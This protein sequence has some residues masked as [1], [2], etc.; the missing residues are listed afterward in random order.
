MRLRTILTS[1]YPLREII[2]RLGELFWF[3][4]APRFLPQ[5]LRY[6]VVLH[7]GVRHIQSG[8]IV[9]EVGFTEILKRSGEAMR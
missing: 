8:E 9:P 5:R 7:E 1:G 3:H 4:T 2:H 6:G